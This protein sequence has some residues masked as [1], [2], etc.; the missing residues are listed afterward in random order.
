[1]VTTPPTAAVS[2]VRIWDPVVRVFHWT[3]AGGV[4]AN[5]TFF[6]N[7]DDW[8]VYIG[9]VVVA[10]LTIRVGW[11]L[12]ASGHPRFTSFVPT[13]RKLLWYFRAMLNRH[14]PR[15]VGHNPAGAAM[16]VVLLLLL[17]TVGGTGWMMGVDAFW[18]IGWVE[19]LHELSANALI[20]A[21]GLHVTGAIFES[22]RH[23]ENLPLAMITGYKRPAE[24][25]DIDNA[26]AVSRR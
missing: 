26:A 2:K 22:I 8:H 11:G 17:A 13:P 9:Y 15:Y 7:Q 25:T 16:I 1:M 10:A 18:G 5:L 12:M 3:V 6:R 20:G 19:E 23:R 21:I 24:G 14:E 4:L